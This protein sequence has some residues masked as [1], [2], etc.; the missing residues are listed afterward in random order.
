MTGDLRGSL[1]AMAGEND[2]LMD[3]AMAGMP[4]MLVKINT[5]SEAPHSFASL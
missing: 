5:F 3:K 4:C 1:K 2:A